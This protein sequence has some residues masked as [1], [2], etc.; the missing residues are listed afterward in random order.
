MIEKQSTG[1][2]DI[3]YLNDHDCDEIDS[4]ES[5]E[6]RIYYSQSG[7][8]AA[9]T[10]P[11]KNQLNL[12]D[13]SISLSIAYTGSKVV[14]DFK[15]NSKYDEVKSTQNADNDDS[16]R[17]RQGK[18]VDASNSNNLDDLDNEIATESDSSNNNDDCLD[19]GLFL[20]G[21]KFK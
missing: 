11:T 2:R 19:V 4:T 13:G 12:F 16:Y 15:Y 1:P 5:C 8:K 14:G 6:D 3:D 7:I 20:D 21:G 18:K 10:T 17:R 9:P